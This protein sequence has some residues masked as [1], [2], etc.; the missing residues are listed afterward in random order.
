[1]L[2]CVFAVA[3]HVLEIGVHLLEPVHWSKAS[4]LI[5]F[6]SL[7]CSSGEYGVRREVWV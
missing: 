2:F 4:N 5:I 1:M 6:V 7:R 3:M